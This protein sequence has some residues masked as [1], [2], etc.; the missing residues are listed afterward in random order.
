MRAVAFL[1]A[2]LIGA[3]AIS[4]FASTREYHPYLTLNSMFRRQE[5]V[6]DRGVAH[7][8]KAL[9]SP[10]DTCRTDILNAV[11]AVAKR[12]A[13]LQFVANRDGWPEALARMERVLRN[14][15]ACNPTNGDLW[16]QLAQTRWFAGG[17]ADE[18][19]NL[20]TLS[21]AYSPTNLDTV[22]KRLRH[23]GEVTR[24]MAALGEELIRRDLRTMLLYAPVTDAVTALSNLP[25]QLHPFVRSEAKIVPN[26]RLHS[27]NLP[28]LMTEGL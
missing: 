22:R 3:V 19:I 17:S 28:G 2:V 5:I 10:L 20:M 27:L 26:A 16:V 21:Q 23:W 18:Q 6:S 12:E 4:E 15:L 1:A 13:D 14:A 9:G 11:V 25:A 7:Y 24:P 8:A